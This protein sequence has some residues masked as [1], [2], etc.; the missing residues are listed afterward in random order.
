MPFPYRL[1]ALLAALALGLAL[2]ACGGGSEEDSS[3]EVPDDAVVLVGD[4]EVAKAEYDQL[5]AQARSTFKQ[6]KQPFPEAGTPEFEQLKHAIVRSLVEEAQFAIGAEELGVEVSDEEVDKRLTE[7]KEQYFQ[8]DDKKYE[9]ELK[10]QG[11]TDAQVREDLRSR[12][13]SEKLFKEVTGDVKVTDAEIKKYYEDNKQAQFGTPASREVRHILVK[14]RARAE[15]LYDQ[16][17]AGANFAAL[18]KQYSQDPSSKDQG[19]KFTAQKGATVAPFDRA[20][21]SLETGELSRPIKTQFGYHLIEPVADVKEAS[22]RPLASVEKEIR[23]TLLRDK[24]NQ[25]MTTWVEELKQRLDDD[26]T[27]AVGFQPPPAGTT[28][29]SGATTTTTE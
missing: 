1:I 2:A 26:V 8:G 29:G 21:F 4:T 9:E 22:A 18:A 6:R 14:T 27:Y 17:Q 23:Q 12:I 13:L 15:Q 19:G 28:T 16:L 11:V 5:L 7:L 20:A 3:S 25:A 24:Q 10:N